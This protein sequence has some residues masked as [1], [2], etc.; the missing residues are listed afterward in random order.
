MESDRIGKREKMGDYCNEER[1][2]T[3]IHPK[4]RFS[5]KE[6]CESMRAEDLKKQKVIRGYNKWDIYKKY[7]LGSRC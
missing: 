1:F 4:N 3:T 5:C 7:G 6:C 2:L